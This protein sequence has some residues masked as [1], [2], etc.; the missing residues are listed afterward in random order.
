MSRASS[1][2]RRV[3]IIGGGLAGLSAAEALARQHRV[4]FEITVLEAKRSVGGRAGSF[5][6]PISSET[7]DYCQHVAMGCCTNLL[8]LLERCG[9]AESL[10]RYSQLR[11]FHPQH[12]PSQF[13]PSRFLPPPL[14][15]AGALSSLTYLNR[16][17]L[18]R[19][20]RALL[21]LLRSPS[22]MLKSQ[23]AGEWLCAHGQDAE[24]IRDFWSVIV[25]SA[26][27]EQV[28]AVSMSAVRKVFVDGF[29][30]A[31]GASDVLVPKVPLSELFGR[32]MCGAIEQLGADIRIATPVQSVAKST[33]QVTIETCDRGR[34]E[35]DHVIVAVPWYSIANLLTRD[36]LPAID[37]FS[38][39]P[40]S[41][42]TGIHLW[43]DRQI[44]DCPHAV[45]V[46]GV[47][48]WVFRQ[49]WTENR[50]AD[51][52]HY[53]QVV[54]SASHH[55]RT[56]AKEQLIETVLSELR[57]AFPMAKEAK[58]VRSRI[59]TDPQSVFSIRPEVDAIRPTARTP[60]PWLHLAGDWIAT[61]WPSTMEGAVIS[62]RMAAS[63]VA[64]Q[65]GFAPIEIDPGLRRGLLAKWLIS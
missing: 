39:I 28:E 37:Q 62:G 57:H 59:V 52:Q 50:S 13:A 29:A 8:G 18:R 53:Y 35:A 49:P 19:V 30:A 42:I 20:R 33:D 60:L 56:L 24:T 14:H 32:R 9:L 7:V 17:Q 43:F 16:E 55:A 64:Q 46:A 45:L 10:Q 65:E 21:R 34:F 25:V 1:Q 5:A 3:V 36:D 11:F 4:R 2:A 54:I 47:A 31:R 27:G 22:D 15:L 44:T 40:A 41:P 23:I 61:G 26:L 51:S 12:G 38:E 63:S 58:L 48:Q 6:D